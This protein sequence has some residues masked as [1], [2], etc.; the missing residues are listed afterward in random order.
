MRDVCIKYIGC[1]DYDEVW[2]IQREV[3]EKLLAWKEALRKGA[4]QRTDAVAE[5]PQEVLL[6][7][8]HPHVYTLGRSGKASNLLVDEA[9]LERIGAQFRRI[10]RGGDVTYHGYGQLVGYP[11]LDLERSDMSL[12]A[13]IRALEESLIAT[14]A[15]YGIV[16]GR[17]EGAA[18]VWVEPGTPRARKIAAIGVRASR[19]VTMH[20][21]ALNVTTDLR[22]FSWINPCGF[23]DRGV[24]SIER[25]TGLR[26]GLDEAAGVY[27]RHFE[28]Y[29]RI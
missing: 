19:C 1:R 14:V 21:F 27:A 12:R 26:P 4:Q 13:Y 15:E 6:L 5:P 7:C 11:L 8:E 28:R 24:T 18:G 9:F 17:M 2:A 25:E 3:F 29:L 20:G 23:T 10:D 22:Y 16:A